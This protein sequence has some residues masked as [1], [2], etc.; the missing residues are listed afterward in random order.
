MPIAENGSEF[1]E[2]SDRAPV[3][4]TDAPLAIVYAGIICCAIMAIIVLAVAAAA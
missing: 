2:Y 4:P 3:V 1:S